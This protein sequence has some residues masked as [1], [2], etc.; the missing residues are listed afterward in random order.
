MLLAVLALPLAAIQGRAEDGLL[1]AIKQRGVLRVAGAVYPP[2]MIR[3]P[4]G[5]YEGADPVILAEMAKSLGVKLEFIDAGWDTVVAGI[6]TGKWDLVAGICNTPKRAQVVD[7]SEAYLTTGGVLAFKHGNPKITTVASANDPSVVFADVAGGWGEQVS[8]VAFPKATHKAFGQA[9]DA[10]MV[11]ELLSGRADAAIFD[12]PVTTTLI[13]ARVGPDALTFLPSATQPMPVQPCA[14]SYAFRKGDDGMKAFLN[15]R[16][17]AMRK[18][19]E[20]DALFKE[21]F[22]PDKIEGK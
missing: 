19:G 17:D 1:A 12:T 15:A 13:I 18:S 11:Q 5:T 20:L 8:K 4:D 14:V 10:D 16:F 3:R 22:V 7:F 9:T 21:W 2:F 6:T